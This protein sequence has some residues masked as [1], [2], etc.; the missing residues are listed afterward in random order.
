MG[1]RAW[2]RL[3][4]CAN[5]HPVDCRTPFAGTPVQWASML[6]AHVRSGSGLRN[7]PRNPGVAHDRP[8]EMPRATTHG[9]H[10]PAVHSVCGGRDQRV[11]WLGRPVASPCRGIRDP[12]PST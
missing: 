2:Y 10:A 4:H 8:P 6:G 9:K 3:A 12:A 11:P 1:G 5:A 7:P